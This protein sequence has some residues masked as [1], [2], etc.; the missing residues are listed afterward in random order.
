MVPGLSRIGLDP[1]A[2]RP[3]WLGGEETR[4]VSLTAPDGTPLAGVTVTVTPWQAFG[5]SAA[6]V[7]LLAQEVVTDAG[8][9]A[10]ID[11]PQTG[12]AYRYRVTADLDAV[13]VLDEELRL[14]D[15]TGLA[16]S[17]ARGQRWH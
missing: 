12:T 2:T 7:P 13:R 4:A 1:L 14:P 6:L 15:S 3:L 10:L 11:L 9:V 8:G 17:N 5:S 16:H